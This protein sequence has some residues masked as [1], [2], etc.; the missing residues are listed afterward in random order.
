MAF[1]VCSAI[2][3]SPHYRI[4]A[5]PAC[6]TAT[7]SPPQKKS[8]SFVG[9]ARQTFSI[10][11][12][13]CLARFFHPAVPSQPSIGCTAIRFHDRDKP[14]RF[15]VARTCDRFPRT[16]VAVARNCHIPAP[17][18]LRKAL[19][20]TSFTNQI[21]HRFPPAISAV[22]LPYHPFALLKV[23]RILSKFRS[24]YEQK[25]VFRPAGVPHCF[26]ET[27]SSA[28]RRQNQINSNPREHKISKFIF[29]SQNGFRRACSPS[30]SSLNSLLKKIIRQ[31]LSRFFFLRKSMAPNGPHRP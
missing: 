2:N 31:P 9:A 24:Q 8:V 16:N 4:S 19:Q 20:S 17:H 12:N 29:S 13:V 5:H 25:P 6:V 7:A 15:S 28:S 21:H 14:P 26:R 23:R 22:W 11:Q 10:S 1:F 18:M 3:Q 30:Q 27:S